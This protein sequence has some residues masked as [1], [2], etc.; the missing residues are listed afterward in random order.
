MFDEV[1]NTTM[2]R[3]LLKKA[4]NRTPP[5]TIGPLKREEDSLTRLDY[6][7]AAL[8]NSYFSTIGEKLV[9]EPPPPPPVIECCEPEVIRNLSGSV[10]PLPLLEI[11]QTNLYSHIQ[12][13]GICSH[14]QNHGISG[15]SM[16]K[17]SNC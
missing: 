6:E 13:H 7:K 14:I 8:I 2:Y 4:T 16:Q 11:K 17:K 1:K 9:D 15:I 10:E 3:N 12:N 5:K